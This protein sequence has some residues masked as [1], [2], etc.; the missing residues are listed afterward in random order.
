ME[1]NGQTLFVFEIANHVEEFTGSIRIE[2]PGD[3]TAVKLKASMER[4]SPYQR[5]RSPQRSSGPG[6]RVINLIGDCPVETTPAF[7]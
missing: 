5:G 6:L 1:A 3:S 2:P 7:P 4:M